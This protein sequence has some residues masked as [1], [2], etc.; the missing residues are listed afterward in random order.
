MPG[1]AWREKKSLVVARFRKDPEEL[2]KRGAR[3]V[4]ES[5]RPIAHVGRSEAFALPPP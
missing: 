5:G 1:F 4:F 2:L 3:P